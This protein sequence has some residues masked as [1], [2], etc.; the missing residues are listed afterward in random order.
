[1]IHKLYY[2][3]C[4]ASLWEL[5]P[6]W[7]KHQGGGGT[8]PR[9][10]QVTDTAECQLWDM[11][12][13]HFS[14][15]GLVIFMVFFFFF[16]TVWSRGLER[17]SGGTH[18]SI[19]RIPESSSGESY[20]N[21]QASTSE[22]GMCWFYRK[23]QQ[24]VVQSELWNVGQGLYQA[25]YDFTVPRITLFRANSDRCEWYTLLIWNWYQNDVQLPQKGMCLV[26]INTHSLF[27]FFFFL[28]FYLSFRQWMRRFHCLL[29]ENPPSWFSVRVQFWY[30][31]LPLWGWYCIPS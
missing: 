16:T 24:D 22:R 30:Q 6:S 14:S 10:V 20:S 29:S 26:Y 5:V 21:W 17:H 11:C 12:T 13:S 18:F 27:S 1:M 9:E 15:F 8:H 4:E 3:D 23:L 25:K 7:A 31:S 19:L 28:S 2:V